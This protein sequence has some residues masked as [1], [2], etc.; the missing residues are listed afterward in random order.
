MG[1]LDLTGAQTVFWAASKYM[2]QRGLQGY[3]RHTVSLNGGLVQSVEGVAL[4]TLAL[5]EFADVAVDTIV[6]PGSPNI[7]QVLDN[8]MP[9]V[10]WV[11]QTSRRHAVLHPCAAVLSCWRRQ[12]YSMESVPP[13]TGL[14]AI[15]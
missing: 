10:E 3:S 1:L 11:H 13:R 7:E 6:V 5:V 4:A 12:G 9:L 14:C 8:S 2:E 15:C